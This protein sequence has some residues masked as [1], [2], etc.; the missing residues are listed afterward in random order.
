MILARSQ[1]ETVQQEHNTLFMHEHKRLHLNLDLQTA[2]RKPVLA[3]ILG[4]DEVGSRRFC[5]Y[6]CVPSWVGVGDQ[7]PRDCC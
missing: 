5:D 2:L 1:A 4:L 3:G 7:I 6:I